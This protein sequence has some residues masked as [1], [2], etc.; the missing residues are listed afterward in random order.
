MSAGAVTVLMPLPSG[1]EAVP[2]FEIRWETAP[3]V[4]PL[5]EEMTL[6]VATVGLSDDGSDRPAELLDSEPECCFMDVGVLVPENLVAPEGRRFPLSELPVDSDRAAVVCTALL[7]EVVDN[8]LDVV[9]LH[10]GQLWLRTDSED[11]L[12]MMRPC[13]HCAV[14]RLFGRDCMYCS[15]YIMMKYILLVLMPHLR[16]YSPQVNRSV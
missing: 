3:A 12:P 8:A 1:A 16:R 11:V 14:A 7:D 4:I 5:A 9:G 6:R 15:V 10:V 13:G 2:Q